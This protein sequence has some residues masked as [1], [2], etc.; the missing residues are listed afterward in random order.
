MY[1]CKIV[2]QTV[3]FPGFYEQPRSR[4]AC[5]GCPSVRQSVRRGTHS[6]RASDSPGLPRHCQPVFPEYHLGACAPILE[7]SS[8]CRFQ[9]SLKTCNTGADSLKMIAVIWLVQNVLWL[10]RTIDSLKMIAVIWLVQNV[11]WLPRTIDS[12]KMIA[13]I[14]LVQNVLWLPRTI[15]SLKII[16]V[17]WLVQNVLWLPRTIDSLKMIVVNVTKL[18]TECTLIS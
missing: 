14:W 18:F 12:L 2:V 7:K 13:V 1:V 9:Q 5:A 17:I 4:S 3:V 6:E 8:E 11:L 16:A 15:D 10:P